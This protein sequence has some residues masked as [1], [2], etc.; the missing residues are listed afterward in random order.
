MEENIN[1]TFS[2][3]HSEFIVGIIDIVHSTET[4]AIL[5]GEKVDDFYTIFLSEISNALRSV[6]AKIIKNTGDGIIYYFP[7]KDNIEIVSTLAI[8]SALLLIQT[9]TSINK[10]MRE[11]GLPEISYRISMSYGPVSVMLNEQGHI[12]DIFGATVNTCA[13]INKLARSNTIVVGEAMKKIL[14]R[15]TLTRKIEDFKLNDSMTFG[16]FEIEV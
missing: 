1:F 2:K 14:S 12:I 8:S 9:R 7:K 15:D 13:K 3:H 5:A 16:V 4:T 11:K 10:Q 6:G